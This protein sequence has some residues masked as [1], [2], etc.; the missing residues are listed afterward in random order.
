MKSAAVILIAAHLTG[1]TAKGYECRPTVT[2]DGLPIYDCG[3]YQPEQILTP[4]PAKCT[5]NI[6]SR[7]G[8]VVTVSA[9]CDAILPGAII[10]SP[11]TRERPA[12]KYQ[13]RME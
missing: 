12:P 5:F 9:P 1:G 11:R 10:S 7:E 3:K 4:P 13:D 2:V 8:L 6:M